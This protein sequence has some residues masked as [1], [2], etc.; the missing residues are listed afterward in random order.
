MRKE[1][2]VQDD[3]R[4]FVR[5][6]RKTTALI[7]LLLLKWLHHLSLAVGNCAPVSRTPSCPNRS[8]YRSCALTW[9][10]HRQ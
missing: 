10:G 8:S 9:T 5:L 7:A 3:Q 2:S 4:T 1:E 6:I